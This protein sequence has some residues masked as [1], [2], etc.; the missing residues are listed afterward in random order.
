MQI[1]RAHESWQMVTLPQTIFKKNIDENIQLPSEFN[2]VNVQ[3]AL[4][5][6]VTR[7]YAD[8]STFFY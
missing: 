4:F 2:S 5:L 7:R 3:V 8:Q 1:G 6:L